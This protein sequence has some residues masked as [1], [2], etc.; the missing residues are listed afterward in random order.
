MQEF[1]EK[2]KTIGMTENEAKVY[3]VLFELKVATAREMHEISKV[4][5]NKV[6]EALANLEEKGF[7]GTAEEEGPSRFFIHDITKT[8]NRLR[9]ENLDRLNEVEQYLHSKITFQHNRPLLSHTLQNTWAIESHL[10]MMFSRSKKEI[11]MI[12]HDTAYVKKH[13]WNLKNLSKK[14]DL[15]LIVPEDTDPDM[16]PIR[17]YKLQPEMRE[18]MDV[19]NTGGFGTEPEFQLTIHADRQ[20]TLIIGKLEGREIGIFSAGN[21]SVSILVKYLLK[22]IIPLTKETAPE[23]PDQTT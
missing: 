19:R 18:F 16:F 23:Q 9:Q 6:Y 10:R 21:P 2:L 12:C 8:F 5:R 15:Y 13:I 7:V 11:V 14:I 1:V 3:A 4:P 22:N 17:C 20:D